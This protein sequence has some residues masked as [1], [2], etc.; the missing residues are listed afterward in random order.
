MGKRK[1]FFTMSSIH[2]F[3]DSIKK[4]LR[5]NPTAQYSLHDNFP[6]ALGTYYSVSSASV[7]IIQKVSSYG[8]TQSSLLPK[9]IFPSVRVMDRALLH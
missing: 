1:G 6:N 2:Q 8:I 4:R 7:E 3:N 5:E 9:E